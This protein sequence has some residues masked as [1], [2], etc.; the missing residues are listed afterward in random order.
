M[1]ALAPAWFA[2]WDWVAIGTLGLALATFAL[3]WT[4]RQVVAA[5]REQVETALQDL[6]L[7]R[8]Q[9]ET[10]RET[11]DSQTAPVLTK[12]PWG[13]KRKPTSFIVSTGEGTSFEDASEI[14]VSQGTTPRYGQ[15]EPRVSIEVPFRNVGNGVAFITSVHVMI[16]GQL[17]D[18]TAGAP[19]VAPGEFDAAMLD[20]GR[21]SPAFDYGISL[22]QEGVDFAVVIG[23]A[24]AGGNPRGA[25]SLDVH[26]D[27][28][29]RGRWYVRQLHVGSTPEDALHRPRLS[30]LPL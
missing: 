18:G 10:L 20:V 4:N 12:V 21:E 23:Y 30:S 8:E 22:E 7:A 9:N 14:T 16:G 25:I 2:E 15:D 27:Q 13:L 1:S 3:A 19:I 29:A 11:L 28:P 24:D 6:A 26:R 5:S 17:F